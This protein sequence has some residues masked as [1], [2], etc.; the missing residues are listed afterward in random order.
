MLWRCKLIISYIVHRILGNFRSTTAV[1]A[2]GQLIDSYICLDI[3]R[4][5]ATKYRYYIGTTR[6]S[7][8]D[9]F[10]YGIMTQTN[11]TMSDACN[12]A[13]PYETG[14]FITLVKDGKYTNDSENKFSTQL[15]KSWFQLLF[16]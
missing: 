1:I 15:H 11:I 5:S 3:Q 13:T 6:E 2:F 10:V 14:T 8:I 4:I 12:R 9:D 16:S 7:S